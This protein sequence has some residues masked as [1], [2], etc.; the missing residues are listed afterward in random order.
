[1]PIGAKTVEK[2]F[3][4]MRHGLFAFLSLCAVAACE[5]HSSIATSSVV[6]QSTVINLYPSQ[7]ADRLY[8]MVTAVGGQ[9]VSLPLA[10]DTGSA[11]ISINALAIFPPNIVTKAG[12]VIPTGEDSVTYDGITVTSLGAVR[13][14][15][16]SE[17]TTEYGNLG[18]AQI[19]F[20]DSA[21]VL[22]TASMPIFLYYLITE[23]ATGEPQM[24]LHKQGF[25]GVNSAADRIMAISPTPGAP[26]NLPC[27]ITSEADCYLVSPFKYIGYFP[28]LHS[29]F[30]LTPQPLQQCD[31]SIPGDCTPA[32]MLQLGLTEEMESGFSQVTLTC[33]QGDYSGPAIIAEYSVCAG[34]I[35]FTT[36]DVRPPSESAVTTLTENVLFDSGNQAAN[37]QV[38]GGS[39]PATLSSGTVVEVTPPSGFTYSY[40]TSDSGVTRTTT[41]NATAGIGINYFTHNAFF[42]DFTRN[43]EGW[44]K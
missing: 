25:F 3:Q 41:G 42:I 26:D 32:P 15:G 10:F 13:L 12:F 34:D 40:V 33:P 22:T 2:L 30:V 21:G 9:G 11:G 36:I 39:L 38:T 5:D 28:P 18:F 7:D 16:G 27:S 37:I 6:E 8:I 4:I 43:T 24:A 14:Y 19:T 1:V 20:G 23:T 17:G 31:I 44:M 35:P 29:G